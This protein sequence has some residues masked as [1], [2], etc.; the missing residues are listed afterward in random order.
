M[1]DTDADMADMLR[2]TEYLTDELGYRIH[3]GAR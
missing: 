2:V 1:I 3:L